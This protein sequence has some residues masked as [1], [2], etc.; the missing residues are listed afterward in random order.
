MPLL[1]QSVKFLSVLSEPDPELGSYISTMAI[2]APVAHGLPDAEL[3]LGLP[4]PDEHEF[5]PA[6]LIGRPTLWAIVQDVHNSLRF[7][8][9]YEDGR[10][11]RIKV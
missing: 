7:G 8:I 6:G 11:H 5:N 3:I 4:L 9:F 2:G 1:N 10:I